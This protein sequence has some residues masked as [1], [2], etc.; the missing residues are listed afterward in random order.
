MHRKIEYLSTQEIMTR[1]KDAGIHPT[2]Q[3]LAICQYLFC[4]ADHPTAEQVKNWVDSHFPRISLATIYNTL[5]LLVQAGLLQEIRF[6]HS[7]KSV[8]DRNTS[9]HFHFLDEE[10]GLLFDLEPADV[11]ILP[12]LKDQFEIH[13]TEL[14]LRGRVKSV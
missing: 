4:D 8:F 5:N 10:S 14:L 11:T 9:P 12:Q 7:E 3:R 13:S 2:A 1:L 6:S